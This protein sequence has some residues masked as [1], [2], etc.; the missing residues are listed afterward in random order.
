MIFFLSYILRLFSC[1]IRCAALLVVS[2][3][4]LC[5]LHTITQ[6]GI[7]TRLSDERARKW[8][9]VPSFCTSSKPALG[10]ASLPVSGRRRLFPQEVKWLHSLTTHLHLVLKLGIREA[11]PLIP[12]MPSRGQCL[13]KKKNVTFNVDI[14]LKVDHSG[15]AV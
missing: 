6:A 11:T 7:S 4:A 2:S 15:R 8:D 13:I 9:S 10:S 5:S 14:H 12:C 3:V 1:P